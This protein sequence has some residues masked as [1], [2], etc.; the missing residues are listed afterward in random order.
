MTIKLLQHELLKLYGSKKYDKLRDLI[1]A[2][3]DAFPG[4]NDLVL[5]WKACMEALAGETERALASLEA[6][7]ERSLCVPGN[8]LEEDPDF[9]GIRGSERFSRITALNNIR[10]KDRIVQQSSKL[11]VPSIQRGESAYAVY[12]LHG[13]THNGALE[14]RVFANMASIEDTLYFPDAPEQDFLENSYMWDDEDT[15]YRYVT[16]IIEKHQQE[17]VK[18]IILAGFSRGARTALKIVYERKYAVEGV[19]AYAP[20]APVRDVESWNFLL[21][22][23]KVPAELIVGEKDELAYEDCG[24]LYGL[25]RKGNIPARLTV[26]KN[27]G[28]DYPVDFE[29]CFTD[30]LRRLRDSAS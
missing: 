28:H 2:H 23:I 15:A 8:Q 26:I 14:R 29:S 1:H 17:S 12:F 6:I 18:K 24:T 13:N 21:D 30:A 19:I 25:L 27:G 11:R 7:L 22:T 20:A 16:D 5:Y 3:L 4:H 9:S 10:R